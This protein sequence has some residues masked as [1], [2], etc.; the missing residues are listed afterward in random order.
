MGESGAIWERW[1]AIALLSDAGGGV[2]SRLFSDTDMLLMFF[3]LL[4]LRTRPDGDE[5]LKISRTQPVN[6]IP[7]YF[8][9]SYVTS[10]SPHPSLVCPHFFTFFFFLPRSAFSVSWVEEPLF[11]FTSKYHQATE[12]HAI[13]PGSLT[14][15]AITFPWL[16]HTFPSPTLSLNPRVGPVAQ[17]LCFY[18]EE[19]HVHWL[20]PAVMCILPGQLWNG[21]F[22][23]MYMLYQ[24]IF[25]KSPQ[26]LK[27]NGVYLFNTMVV[28]WRT[29][30]HL[31]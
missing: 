3:L 15:S 23:V 22:T 19:M 11:H 4:S 28:L 1:E 5:W 27:T 16:F 9:L 18:T 12:V 20:R 21:R 17:Q 14:E 24:M 26:F 6:F 2:C 7:K 31:V 29:I 30:L 8:F 10:V 25:N 13:M